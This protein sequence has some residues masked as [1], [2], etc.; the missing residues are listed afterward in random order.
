MFGFTKRVQRVAIKT[1][2]CETLTWDY[3]LSVGIM[4]LRFSKTNE[5]VYMYHNRRYD[6]IPW[7]RI[8]KM[9]IDF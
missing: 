1:F 7:C 2:Q 6:F 5:G 8:S 9:E 4:G 3:S